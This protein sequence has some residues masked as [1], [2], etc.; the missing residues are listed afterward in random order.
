MLSVS[1]RY[2]IHLKVAI[3]LEVSDPDV[4]MFGI[5]VR[6]MFVFGSAPGFELQ[7]DCE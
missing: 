7:I 4:Q 6:G 5:L 2:L 1:E 3:V